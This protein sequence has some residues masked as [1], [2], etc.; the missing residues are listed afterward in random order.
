MP[1]LMS[2]HRRGQS[3][4]VVLAAVA[5]VAGL[6]LE[7]RGQPPKGKIPSPREPAPTRQIRVPQNL[8][9][10]K[11]VTTDVL[12]ATGRR[13]RDHRDHADAPPAADAA[14]AALAASS[15]PLVLLVPVTVTKLPADA[16]RVSCDA[17]YPSSTHHVAEK[18]GEGK[19]EQP[20]PAGSFRGTLAVG[21]QLRPGTS[22]ADVKSYFCQLMVHPSPRNHWPE[23]ANSR[24]FGDIDQVSLVGMVKGS[25]P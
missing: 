9:V 4:R 12:S 7:A 5:L 13:V 23:W 2:W 11:T 15:A 10:A 25:L 3:S 6:A 17:G 16:I 24:Q 19:T 1:G 20:T 18:L 14:A 22:V 8:P 21:I